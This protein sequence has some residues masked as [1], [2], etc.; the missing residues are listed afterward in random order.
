MHPAWNGDLAALMLGDDEVSMG[1]PLAR[2]QHTFPGSSVGVSVTE[3]TS[4]EEPN[5]GGGDDDDDDDELAVFEGLLQE[6]LDRENSNDSAAA[7]VFRSGSES[8]PEEDEDEEEEMDAVPP[9]HL[10]GGMS[11]IPCEE[12]ES[13]GGWS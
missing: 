10:S 13:D 9:R 5:G 1:S 11:P 12:E 7:D 2:R 8:P 6:R 4:G 3:S